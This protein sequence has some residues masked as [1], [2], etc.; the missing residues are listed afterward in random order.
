MCGIVGK[1]AEAKAEVSGKLRMLSQSTCLYPSPRTHKDWP[2]D[3]M[4]WYIIA[5]YGILVYLVY[6][7]IFWYLKEVRLT[8]TGTF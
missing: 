8:Y 3:S 6:Y 4:L 5:Y 1:E 2:K 7:S